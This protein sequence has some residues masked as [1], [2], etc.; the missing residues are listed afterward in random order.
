MANKK[1]IKQAG[2]VQECLLWRMLEA[3]KQIVRMLACKQPRE[4]ESKISKSKQEEVG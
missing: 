4:Q 1:E 2:K 3:R